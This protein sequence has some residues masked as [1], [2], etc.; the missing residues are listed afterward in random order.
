MFQEQ[1]QKAYDKIAPAPELTASLLERAAFSQK[2]HRMC[3]LQRSFAAALAFALCMVVVIPVCAAEVPAFYRVL[4]FI[5]PEMADYFVPV[6]KKST[7]SGITM[8]VEAMYLEENR[9]QVV[10]SFYDEAGS[11]AKY[12]LSKNCVNFLFTFK[13]SKQTVLSV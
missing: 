8:E 12:Y 2:Q 1:Y 10:V 9:A 7:S 13:C 6:E 11:A 4:D 3:V 5:S